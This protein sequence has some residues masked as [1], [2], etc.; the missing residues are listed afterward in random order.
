MISLQHLQKEYA[1]RRVV[2]DLSFQARDGQITGLLGANG[3]GK[4]TTLRMIAGLLE[5][6][7]GSIRITGGTQALGALLDHTGL[8]SRL[9]ARENIAYFGRLRRLPRLEERVAEIVARL[10]LQGLEDRPVGQFSVGERMKVAL[11]RV[12]VHQPKNLV[13][14]EPTNGLDLTT[15]RSLRRFW[16]EMRD[17]GGCLL[18]SSHVLDDIRAIC[19]RIVIMHEGRVV[20][21]GTEEELCERAQ[22]ATLEDAYLLMT[23]MREAAAC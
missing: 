20:A 12:L 21:E 5:P 3:A 22:C 23:A 6:D 7:A 19:D 14:D 17:A 8:Y 16:R 13:L 15:V 4:T 9:T 11:G 18:F 2:N 10:E 1:G